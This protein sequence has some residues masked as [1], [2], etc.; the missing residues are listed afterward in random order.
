MKSAIS[1]LA[2]LALAM[3]ASADRR[4]KR[5]SHPELCQLKTVFVEGN[6]ESASKI[7]DE[8]PKRTWLK[9]AASKENVDAVLA[10]AETKSTGGFPMTH[11]QTT[12]SGQLTKAGSDEILWSDSASFGELPR[13]SGAGSA[14]KILL[15]YL[16]VDGDCKQ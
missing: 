1:L 4:H 5:G 8:I 9:L 10:I 12:V 15:N 6:S 7:R 3:P 14:A 16:S 11:E 2:L 13:G